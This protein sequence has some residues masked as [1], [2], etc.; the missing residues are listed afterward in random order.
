MAKYVPKQRFPKM[1]VDQKARILVLKTKKWPVAK[2]A[3]EIKCDPK[4]VRNVWNKFEKTQTIA[5]IP[6]PGRKRKYGTEIRNK[7]VSA[8]EASPFSTVRQL[9]NDLRL[10]C[11]ISTI[12]RIL[13]K[14]GLPGYRARTKN[15]LTEAHKTA[16]MEFANKHQDFD[17]KNVIFSD[18]KTVQNYYNGKKYVRR[19]RGQA[20]NER[21]VIRTNRARQFKINLW[22][23]I[24]PE[25]FDL[26]LLPERHNKE[27]Y[28]MTLKKANIS[29]I[30]DSKVFMHD[31]A[32][33]HKAEIV[34]EY[35]RK[36]EV[37]VLPW[38]A[39]SPDLNPIKNI[40][41]LMQKS[42]YDRMLMGV[43]INTKKR[44]FALCKLCFQEVCKKHL[45]KLFESVSTRNSNVIS[46]E[47][48]LTKY[49]K[50]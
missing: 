37:D 34:T 11:S 35:L 42:V 30:A 50:M 23:Y 7:V 36:E 31:N 12:K 47:G 16:R 1:T 25:S 8:S 24:T 43:N 22:G 27:S 14:A 28:L 13:R 38:P 21:Y 41:A 5:T 15:G 2:I 48:G 49:K 19:P 3:R 18:E 20:W 6:N 32:A 40:W 46:L 9:R 4:T 33:I 44:L 39:R 29:E 17:W 10:M 45:K 26:H